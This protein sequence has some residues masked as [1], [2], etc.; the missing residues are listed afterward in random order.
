VVILDLRGHQ[1]ID[2]TTPNM[3][4]DYAETLREHQCRLM[5]AEVEAAAR[6]TLEQPGTSTKIGSDNVF[7]ATNR[8]RQSVLEAQ[9]EAEQWLAAG[10]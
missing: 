7:G 3:L 4:T 10:R 9:V 1:A 2:T 8:V 5:L 6:E